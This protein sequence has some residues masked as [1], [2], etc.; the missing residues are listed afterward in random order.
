MQKKIKTKNKKA[1]FGNNR[2]FTLVEILFGVGIFVIIVGALTFFSRN[3]WIYG[4]YVSVGLSDANS[5]RIALKTMVAEIR[6]AST[7]ETGSYVIAL[8]TATAFTFYSDI[9]NDGLKEKVRYFLNGSELQKGVIK[10]T[11]SPLF[12]NV[13]NEKISTLT[14]Y[15]TNDQKKPPNP[16]PRT[17]SFSSQVY[18]RNLKENLRPIQR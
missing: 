18:L 5:G 3:I 11:G 14:S 15:L 2:G 10:P 6:T 8:A 17:T 13:V 4:S 12:Y 7:A 1:D 9:D 16:A